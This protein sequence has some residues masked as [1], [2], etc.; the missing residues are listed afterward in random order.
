MIEKD[1]DLLLKQFKSHVNSL[2][3]CEDELVDIKYQLRG[4][5]KIKSQGTCEEAQ[6]DGT[7]IYKNTIITLEEKL[8]QVRQE[9][10]Y[11][12]FAVRQVMRMLQLLNEDEV[13]LLE[14]YYWDE[15]PI[16]VIG[17]RLSYSKSEVQRQID[18]VKEKLGHVPKK[19]SV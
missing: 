7:K 18:E 13:E 5:K 6:P 12:L 16:R 10:N 8:Q 9:R 1:I 4:I 17:S 14:L 15:L 11:H 3:N 2:M 19:F